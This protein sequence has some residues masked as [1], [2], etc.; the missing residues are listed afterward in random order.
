MIVKSAVATEF[1]PLIARLLGDSTYFELWKL[2]RKGP[3]SGTARRTETN[4][5]TF[6]YDP[7]D[8]TFTVLVSFS[9]G[10]DPESE[11]ILKTEDL[12]KGLAKHTRGAP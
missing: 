3:E 11:V 12:L 6:D 2:L 1:T 9:D 7:M 5:L 10:T 4:T 8:D